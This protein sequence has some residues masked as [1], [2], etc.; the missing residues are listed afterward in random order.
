MNNK[1]TLGLLLGLI[2]IA[3][4]CSFFKTEKK[5]VAPEAIPATEIMEVVTTETQELP[6]N[7]MTPAEA[8]ELK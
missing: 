7:P 6:E 3:P 2:L 5:E 1:L 8:E 4:A